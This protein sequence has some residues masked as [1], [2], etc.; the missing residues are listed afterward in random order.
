MP[1]PRGPA[2]G[3]FR[4]AVAGLGRTAVRAP[5]KAARRHLPG[6]DAPNAALIGWPCSGRGGRGPCARPARGILR[7][8][9]LGGADGS[10][11]RRCPPSDGFWRH[12]A[13]GS[14]S[15]D[16]AHRPNR[17]NRPSRPARVRAQARP[18]RPPVRPCLCLPALRC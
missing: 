9:R 3:A 7:C 13:G 14:R 17:P 6:S 8:V 4:R 12:A 11:A 5:L 15:G 18:I 1:R 16:S 10:V 2:S